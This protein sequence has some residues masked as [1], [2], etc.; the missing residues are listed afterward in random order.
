MK[1]AVLIIGLV[2]C[3]LGSFSQEY[4]TFTDPRDGKVYKTVKIGTQLVMAENLAYKPEKGTYWIN[5]YS[6]NGIE[7]CEYRYDWVTANSIAPAGWHL[8][9]REEWKTL[10]KYLGG[11]ASLV[12]NAM[13]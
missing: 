6:L 5:N 10:W 13:I 11:D 4:R 2:F 8:P 7:K 12:Y 3:Y 9:T 1:K